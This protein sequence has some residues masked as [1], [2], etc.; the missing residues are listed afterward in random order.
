[1]SI[2][3]VVSTGV[4]TGTCSSTTL[5]SEGHGVAGAIP[6]WMAYMVTRDPIEDNV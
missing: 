1:M 6:I 4:S 2:A 5:V 3:P